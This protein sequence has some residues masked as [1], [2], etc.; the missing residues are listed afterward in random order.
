VNE[1]PLLGPVDVVTTIDNE[2]GEPAGT[3]AIIC[4]SDQELMV[5]GVAPNVTTPAPCVAPYPVPL[6][7]IG[8][9]ADALPG[10]T[11]FMAGGIT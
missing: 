1:Y 6:I 9:P 4:V 11:P 10:L 8:V 7:V 5:A 2:P 3:T